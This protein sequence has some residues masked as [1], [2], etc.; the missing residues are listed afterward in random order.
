[1][2]FVHFPKQERLGVVLRRREERSGRVG[3]HAAP[4]CGPAVGPR[5][6][7]GGPTEQNTKTASGW[8]ARGADPWA[9]SGPALAKRIASRL[10]GFPLA[11]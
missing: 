9:H 8:A 3:L 4:T 6:A 2:L 5:W 11:C 7:R 10:P 1:M